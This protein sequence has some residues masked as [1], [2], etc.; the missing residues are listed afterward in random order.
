MEKF[1]LSQQGE[2]QRQGD[3]CMDS[4]KPDWEGPHTLLIGKMPPRALGRYSRAISRDLGTSLAL[5][6]FSWP[7]VGHWW[8]RESQVPA[9]QKQGTL[10]GNL[11]RV[12]RMRW[13]DIHLCRYF[14]GRMTLK[15][16]LSTP[17]PNQTPKDVHYKHPLFTGH[18]V[19]WQKEKI[20]G[21]Y[22]SFPMSRYDTKD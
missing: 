19:T 15:I 1:L 14:C 4:G 17:P 8:N 12:P 18:Y 9:R 2:S 3:K 20:Y 16:G 13:N 5:W 22:V 21:V 11:N 6:K 10:L 7:Q